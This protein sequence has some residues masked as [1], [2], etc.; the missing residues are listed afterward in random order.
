M[1]RYVCTL[2]YKKS[3]KGKYV[4]AEDR[5]QPLI[6][7]LYL[8]KDKVGDSPPPRIRVIVEAN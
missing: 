1:N 3:T 5:E 4:Y 7:S 8:D 6:Q 2:A